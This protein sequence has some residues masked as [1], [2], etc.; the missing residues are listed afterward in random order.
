MRVVRD[1]LVRQSIVVVMPPV[2]TF[3]RPRRRDWFIAPYRT[4]DFRGGEA[5]LIVRPDP[6]EQLGVRLGGNALVLIDPR[7]DFFAR[8]G[9]EPLLGGAVR[10]AE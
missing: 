7:P 9:R 8:L 10:Q 6:A 4:I 2:T 3:V 1:L 5:A